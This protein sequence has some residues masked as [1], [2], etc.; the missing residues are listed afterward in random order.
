MQFFCD[1]CSV[2]DFVNAAETTVEFSKQET[3]CNAV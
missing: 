1:K 2:F 3:I